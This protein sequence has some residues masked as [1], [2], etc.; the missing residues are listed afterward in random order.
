[1]LRAVLLCLLLDAVLGQT[2]TT[3]CSTEGS[4]YTWSE[5]ASAT[6]RTITTK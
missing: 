1:M 2:T 4:S 6:T 5:T 3:T